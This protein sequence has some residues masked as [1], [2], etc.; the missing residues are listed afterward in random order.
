M[1]IDA[2]LQMPHTRKPLRGRMTRSLRAVMDREIKMATAVRSS[3]N[4][5]WLIGSTGPLKPSVTEMITESD[6]LSKSSAGA[7]GR[8][9]RR[10]VQIVHCQN[11]TIQAD[12]RPPVEMGV[13]GE[14]PLKNNVA[15][16]NELLPFFEK[17]KD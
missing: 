9:L 1:H 11:E 5:F 15:G 17:A 14:V 10:A 6:L 3:Q 4:L 2:N 12:S 13:I 16:S 8:G 7:W